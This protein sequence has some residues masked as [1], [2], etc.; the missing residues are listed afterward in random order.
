MRHIQSYKNIPTFQKRLDDMIE[1]SEKNNDGQKTCCPDKDTEK[2]SLLGKQS[3]GNI[4]VE[5]R[6]IKLLSCKPT[7]QLSLAASELN[8]QQRT[9]KPQSSCKGLSSVTRK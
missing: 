5:R 8:Q 6:K 3:V 7:P 9:P 2:V 4:V 1:A